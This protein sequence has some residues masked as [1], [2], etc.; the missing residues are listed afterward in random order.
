MSGGFLKAPR[1]RVMWGDVNLS[2]YTGGGG[3]PPVFT[4]EG[5]KGAPLVYDVR[6][7]MPSEGSAPTAEFKW[8]PTGPG[9]AA[10]EYFISTPEYVQGRLSIEFFYPRGKKFITYWRWSGQSINYGND[11]SVTVKLQSELSGL[12]NANLRNTAQAYDEEKGA[13]MTQ[14]YSKLT[15]QYGMPSEILKFSKVAEEQ[16]QK[17]K[18]L[19]VYGNDQTFGASV[20][21]LAKQAGHQVTANNVKE[22]NLVI[23]APYLGSE[24][25]IEDGTA[26]QEPEPN[27]RYGYLLGPSLINSV[28]RNYNWKPP[29]QDNAKTPSSQSKAENPQE[30]PVS[31]QP[32]SYQDKAKREAATATSAPLGTALARPN[33]GVQ[34]KENPDGPKRQVQLNEEKGSE[35]SFDTLMCPALVGLKANDIL[36]IPSLAGDYIE[37]WIV[38]T[39]DY[40]SQRGA[41]NISVRATRTFGAKSA[42]NE[43]A[44]EKFK[45]LA[46]SKKLIGP[47]ATLEAWDEYAW[48][49]Q[50]D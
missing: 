23:N 15:E 4:D 31:G 9:Y 30:P 27:V 28:S 50:G 44:S 48:S 16:M 3:A 45:K 13:E 42:M 24:E 40:T 37:D 43:K 33:P 5:E 10:Y 36:F 18:L 34:N 22:S 35:L 12:V 47:D 26:V 2:A 38:Q 7:S 19:N 11:M 17:V 25:E 14:V 41:V 6:I 32:E 20:S 21:N 46:Q 29:Q 8:D 39:V 1:V 49:L